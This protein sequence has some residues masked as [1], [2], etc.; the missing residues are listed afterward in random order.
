M[1]LT[2]FVTEKWS[3]FYLLRFENLK[4]ALYAVILTSRF[5]SGPVSIEF[6]PTFNESLI[7]ESFG[8]ML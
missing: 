6:S 2:T 7:G 8:E 1:R 4:K 5:S 3:V